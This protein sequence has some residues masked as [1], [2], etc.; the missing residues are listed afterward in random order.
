MRSLPRFL[1]AILLVCSLT[2]AYGQDLRTGVALSDGRFIAAGEC[3]AWLDAEGNV[4]RIKPLE[5]P[6]TDLVAC[7]N[8]LYA[9]DTDGIELIEMDL[10]GRV[11]SRRT[12][13]VQGRLRGLAADGN[14]LW[15]VTDAGEILHGNKASGWRVL[16]FNAQYKGYYPRMDFRA[17]AIG[18]GSMMVAGFRPDGKTVA[19]T[20]ARGT[21][22]N[23]RS[24]DYTE[25]GLPCAFSADVTGLNHDADQDRFYLLG[26]GGLQLA[27]PG[28][29]H[30]NSLQ[31]YPVDT[32]FARIPAAQGSLLLGSDGFRRIEEK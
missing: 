1:F 7:G 10:G 32:L 5:K 27:L 17:I 23:E 4:Q 13:S 22:W 28:C 3:L 12:L 19:Y 21:V 20:S 9:L 25:R 29:S 30:C 16:D 2:A 11:L 26:S 24:L 31:K 6:L 15:A 8:R 18:G 14:I